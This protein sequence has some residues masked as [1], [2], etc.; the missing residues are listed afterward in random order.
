[1]DSLPGRG[2]ADGSGRGGLVGYEDV[3]DGLVPLQA[4]ENVKRKSRLA[5]DAAD[6]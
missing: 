3:L 1:M 4:D 5:L 6:R 2:D